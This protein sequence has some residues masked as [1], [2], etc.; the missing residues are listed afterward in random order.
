VRECTYSENGIQRSGSFQVGSFEDIRFKVIVARLWGEASAAIMPFPLNLVAL[1]RRVEGARP[2]IYGPRE[3]VWTTPEPP[4]GP[5]EYL[6][7]PKYDF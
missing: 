4:C 1:V 2:H 5:P 3:I 7:N 6:W